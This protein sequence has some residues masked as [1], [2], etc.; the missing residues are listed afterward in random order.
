MTIGKKR[1]DTRVAMAFLAARAFP[2][3]SGIKLDVYRAERKAGKADFSR[4]NRGP[5]EEAL[6]QISFFY[7]VSMEPEGPR[8]FLETRCR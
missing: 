8:S 7:L 5:A 4:A 2:C 6:L 1:T 3:L